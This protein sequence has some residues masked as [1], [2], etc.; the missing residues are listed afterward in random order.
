[1]LAAAVISAIVILWGRWQVEKSNNTVELVMDY[2]AAELLCQ[3]ADYPLDTFLRQARDRGLT[4]VAVGERTIKDIATLGQ[5]YAFSGRQ[6]LDYDRLSPVSDPVLRQMIDELRLCAG[7]SYLFARDHEV[8]QDLLEILPVRLEGERI[9]TFSS[10]RLGSFLETARGIPDLEKVN[11]G[12]DPGAAREVSE[13][14]LRIVARLRNYPGATP[15]K[16]GFFFN[17]IPYKESISL[18][19]FEGMEVLGYPD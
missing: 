8:F 10:Q 7:N 9:S 12:L 6:I 3:N 17:R 18:V 4:S 5:V 16:I 11:I 15:H 2:R 14:G 1:M 19:I 13:A